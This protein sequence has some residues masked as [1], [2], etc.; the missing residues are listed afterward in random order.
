MR[1]DLL[2]RLSNQKRFGKSEYV[3]KLH[4]FP[5]QKSRNPVASRPDIRNH[6]AAGLLH[7]PTLKDDVPSSSETLDSEDA[8]KFETKE[9]EEEEICSIE[10]KRKKKKKT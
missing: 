6:T 7:I 1:G 5:I 4:N 2:E 3:K 9:E 8:D 10:E